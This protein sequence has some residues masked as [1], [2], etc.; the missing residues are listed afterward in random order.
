MDVAEIVGIDS[1]RKID[2]VWSC[3]QAAARTDVE[4]GICLIFFAGHRNNHLFLSMVDNVRLSMT[5]VPAM[6]ILQAAEPACHSIMMQMSL[7]ATNLPQLF[8]TDISGIITPSSYYNGHRASEPLLQ[9][10]NEQQRIAIAT[11]S[12]TMSTTSIPKQSQILRANALS[13]V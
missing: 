8:I 3:A 10:L 9:F 6:L 11:F 4:T 13:S 7:S 5:K 12:N 1:F 2:G